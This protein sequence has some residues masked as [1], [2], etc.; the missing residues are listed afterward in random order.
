MSYISSSVYTRLVCVPS[1]SRGISSFPDYD[2]WVHNNNCLTIQPYL[3]PQSSLYRSYR[4]NPDG[5]KP[6]NV[7]DVPL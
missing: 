4:S 7:S 2:Y 1:P 3:L 5:T 6:W